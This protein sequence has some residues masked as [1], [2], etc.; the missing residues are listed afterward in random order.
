[1]QDQ[2]LAKDEARRTANY[3]NIKDEIKQDVGE[4]IA[5]EADTPTQAQVEQEKDIAHG[6]RQKAVNEVAQTEREVERGRVAARV[7]QIV[8]YVFFLI[9]GFLGIRLLLELLAARESAEFVKW[10]KAVTGIFYWPFEG[11]VASP[12]VEGHTLAL[13]II[14]AMIVYVLLHMAINGLLRMMAHRRTA[15]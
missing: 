3:E 15:V 12:S 8:D 9:Y 1:M 13:P 11:I 5:A 7:S 14:V 10:V 2:K 4:E 6:M